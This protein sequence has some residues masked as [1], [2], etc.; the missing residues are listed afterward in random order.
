MITLHLIRHGE[1][2]WHAEN[3]YAGVSD[4]ELTERGRAQAQSLAPWAAAASIDVVVTSDLRRAA[5]TGAV[6]ARAAGVPVIMD[7][8]IREVSFGEAEGLTRTEMREKFPAA[9]ADFLASP[10][11]SPLPG[12]ELGAHAVDRGLGAIVELMQTQEETASI[13][14]VAHT[15]LIRLM[16]CRFLGIPLDEYRR[17]FPA[18]GNATIT[19]LSLPRV[20]DA[21]ELHGVGALMQYNAPA[22]AS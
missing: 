20:S 8:G 4:I 11:S 18:L 21:S 6:V 16:L 7:R 5:E 15:T 2:V 14:L 9:L 17:R 19:T 22:I 1:T 3:R 13:A 10:A 12:G